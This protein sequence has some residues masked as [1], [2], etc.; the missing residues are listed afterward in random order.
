MRNDDLPLFDLLFGTFENPAGFE[1][2]TGLY[3]GASSRNLD[4][5]LL[6]N[7]TP[8]RRSKAFR[9]LKRPYAGRGA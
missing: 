4:L 7:L 9:Q 8:Q 1:H 6:R 5:L 2:E 3:P